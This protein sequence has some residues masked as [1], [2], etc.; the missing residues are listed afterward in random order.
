MTDFSHPKVSKTAAGG[1]TVFLPR[2]PAGGRFFPM[3]LQSIDGWQ[4]SPRI[5]I[6]RRQRIRFCGCGPIA[7]KSRLTLPGLFSVRDIYRSGKRIFLE[8]TGLTGVSGTYTVLVD[9]PAYRRIGVLWRPYKVR[10][11]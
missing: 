3:K 8:V 9:G 5:L 10:R 11:V 2:F 6:Q 1:P 4:L 7:G